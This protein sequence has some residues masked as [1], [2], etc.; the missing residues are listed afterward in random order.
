MSGRVACSIYYKDRLL[1]A[2]YL[3]MVLAKQI[4]L[5]TTLRSFAFA[6]LLSRVKDGT[7][8]AVTNVGNIVRNRYICTFVIFNACFSNHQV[9]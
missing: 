7:G 9:S 1:N 2:I 4:L 8:N 5:T 3:I 6:T